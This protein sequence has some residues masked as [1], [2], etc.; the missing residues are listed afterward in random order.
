[1]VAATIASKLVKEVVEINVRAR[2]KRHAEKHV[3]E[4]AWQVVTELVLSLMGRY[5]YMKTTI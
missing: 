2:V 3:R 5:Y 4:P 1:M